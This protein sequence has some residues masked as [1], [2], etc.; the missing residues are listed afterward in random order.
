MRQLRLTYKQWLWL[1]YTVAG[2]LGFAAGF[3]YAI[4]SGVL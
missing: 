3:A 4:F 2:V 1:L